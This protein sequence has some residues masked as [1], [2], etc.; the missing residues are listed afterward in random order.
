[1]P[2]L[3][4]TWVCDRNSAVKPLFTPNNTHLRHSKPQLFLTLFA[5]NFRLQAHTEFMSKNP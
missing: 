5:D 1:M 3:L 2:G 4:G